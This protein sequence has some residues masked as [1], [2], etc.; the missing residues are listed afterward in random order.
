LLS[1]NPKSF[2]FTSHIKNL[3][4][5]I[6]KSLFLPIVLYGCETWSLTLRKE[7]RLRVFENRML[8]RIFGPK[9]K[10][11]GSWRKLHNDE[12]HDLYSLLNIVRVIKS[13]RMRWAGH[14]APMGEERVVYRVL[15][16]ISEV[17]RPLGRPRRS[18][19]D[20]IKLDLREIGIDGANWIQLAQDRVRWR[21]FVNT[22]M[23]LRV[24]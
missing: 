10:E 1:F 3:K 19:E 13:R 14:V 21:A 11:D 5:K 22:A 24:P 16:E 18:W 7:H 4:I 8:R 12:L 23:N 6:Y 17:K 20:N 15:V 2:V 9:R